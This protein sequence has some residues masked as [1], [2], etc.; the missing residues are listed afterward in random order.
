MQFLLFDIGVTLVFLGGYR[1]VDM[2]Q[3][4][5]ALAVPRAASR[6]PGREPRP[7]P[8]SEGPATRAPRREWPRLSYPR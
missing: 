1:T 7:A 2:L 4:R 5:R 8:G 6:T 3:R